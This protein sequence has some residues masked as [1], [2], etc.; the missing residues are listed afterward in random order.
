MPHTYK[1]KDNLHSLIADSMSDLVCLHDPSG[2]YEWISPSSQRILGRSPE[3]LLG[4]NPYDYFHPEDCD[5]IRNSTHT[6]ALN[7][8]GNISV[9]YRM[10]HAEGHY[11][12]MESLTQPIRD[13]AGDVIRLH[14]TSRDIT[15]QKGLETALAESESLYRSVVQSLAEGVIVFSSDG[16]ILTF[17]DQASKVLGM[18]PED[19][20][21]RDPR[22]TNWKA[23]HLDGTEF[24]LDELPLMVTLATGQACRNVRMG[25]IHQAI[26]QVRW[27][28]INAEPVTGS[29][30]GRKRCKDA[31]V[32]LTL[33]DISMVM[34]QEAV[35]KQWSSVF[36]H[37]QEPIILVDHSGTVENA[38]CAFHSLVFHQADTA[39]GMNWKTFLKLTGPDTVAEKC[40]LAAAEALGTWRGELWLR[41]SKG[42]LHVTWASISPIS[43]NS[44]GTHHY[45][46]I[47]SRFQEKHEQEEALRIQAT[48]DPLTQLPN[49]ILLMDRFEMALKSAHRY[50]ETMGCL[51]IDLD[52]FK[53]INDQYGHATGDE[54]LKIVARRLQMAIREDDTLARL[55]GDEFIILATALSRE[56]S[57]DKVAEK[58]LA[59]FSKPIEVKGQSRVLEASIGISTYP[60]NA[61]NS[62]D[63]L[64]AADKAMYRAKRQGGARWEKY[65]S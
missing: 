13:E 40:L 45:V 8:Q 16:K 52:N 48:H 41:D 46:I 58:I 23:L 5:H 36:E 10:R 21:G 61:D 43:A 62:M 60:R 64:E 4:K 30:Q 27:L 1:D 63:L 55:G 26:D 53:P 37:S 38:N 54:V 33:R 50:G 35:L 20:V 9:R 42:S 59:V 19:L 56:Q 28:S 22:E 2:V 14:T 65:G 11:I 31:A 32:V 3:E 39:I 49:R 57:V 51:Y 18:E 7:G 47:F 44:E 17:N 25:V 34:Q 15:H 24:T 6:P 29:H 12:W